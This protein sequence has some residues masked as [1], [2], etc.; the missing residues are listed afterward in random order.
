MLFELKVPP[1]PLPLYLVHQLVALQSGQLLGPYQER[2]RLKIDTHFLGDLVHLHRFT[3]PVQERHEL[4]KR[5]IF[6]EKKFF[7]GKRSIYFYLFFIFYLYTVCLSLRER[8]LASSQSVNWA[9]ILRTFPSNSDRSVSMF[10]ILATVASINSLCRVVD[11]VAAFT[12]SR[13]F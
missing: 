8:S 11:S 3:Q 5:A 6:R 2:L 10:R 1:P 9:S 7:V 4:E 12:L 13:R